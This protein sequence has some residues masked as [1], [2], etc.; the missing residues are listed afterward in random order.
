MY[1]KRNVKG[2]TLIELLV[3]IT[4]IGLLAGAGLAGYGPIMDK[5]REFRRE[6]DMRT[7]YKIFQVYQMDFNRYPT[8]S[9]SI[10][11]S[12]GVKDLYILYDQGYL[13]K[14][15]ILQPPGVKLVSFSRDPDIDEFDSK[16]I[17]YSYNSSAFP[18]SDPPEPILADQGVSDGIL[19]EN[20]NDPGTKPINPRRALVLMT[21][22]DVLKIS[23]NKRGKLNTDDISA[24]QWGKL[25]D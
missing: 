13:K 16:H 22:G 14:L 3:V 4:I 19:N 11:R 8:S 7:L 6:Q 25:I 23:A 15:N 12:N 24:D 2:F 1:K 18:G 5:V 10:D 9:T 20:S 21:D 17:G